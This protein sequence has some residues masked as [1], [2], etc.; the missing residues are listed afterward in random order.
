MRNPVAAKLGPTARPE[1][2][3]EL[4]ARLNPDR[5]PGRLTLITRLGADKVEAL[6]PPLVRAVRDADHPVVWVCDPMHGN[7]FKAASGHKTRHV[8]AVITE[9]RGFFSVH[10]AEGTWPGGV[11]VELTGEDVTECLG[12]SEEVL[13]SHLERRYLS[14]CDP[15]LNARQSLDLAFQV[16][17]LLSI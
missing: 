1:E 5:I 9:I 17:E 10:R 3:V 16:A 13:D 14:A 7:T 12:G 4:C 15:R 8:D 11:H 2:V 6:L